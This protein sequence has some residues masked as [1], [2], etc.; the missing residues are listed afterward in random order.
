VFNST[1]V[2]VAIGLFLIYLILG[3]LVTSINEFIA[4]GLGLRAENLSEA[5]HSMFDG[6]D[7]HRIAEDILDHPLVLSLSRKQ[8]GINLVGPGKRI[9]NTIKRPSAL[10]EDVFVAVL[11]DLRS[12]PPI[13]P[14]DP[15]TFAA[16]DAL[17]GPPT[18]D[19]ARD[20]AAIGAWYREVMER[21][22]GWYKK[23]AQIMSFLVAF[24]VVLALNGDTILIADRL[25]NS[26]IERAKIAAFAEKLK[27]KPANAA[28]GGTAAAT[29]AGAKTTVATTGGGAGT[30]D[31]TV[32]ND[33]E[34]E[35]EPSERTIEVPAEL[36]SSTLSFLGWAE[37][38]SNDPRRTPTGF[39]DWLVKLVG[40]AITAFAASLGAPF[41]FDVLSK[42]MTV[43]TGGSPVANP[44]AGK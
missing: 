14:Y 40:L 2:E 21:V 15:A 20:K 27:E 41:W 31:A 19:P 25:S 13:A 29:A 42:I 7:R 38:S 6:P 11:A 43:R 4:Q 9:G 1:V 23:R 16:M 35:A 39:N 24:G 28:P 36:R 32:G 12:R 8:L 33:S 17:G 10:T 18:G 44:G 26:P 37:P 30:L 22:R 3:L 5:L 34:G